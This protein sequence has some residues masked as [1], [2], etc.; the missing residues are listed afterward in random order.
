MPQ[1]LAGIPI[2]N[3]LFNRAICKSLPPYYTSK[4]SLMSGRG[5]TKGISATLVRS[6]KRAVW[7][8]LEEASKS[9]FQLK[10]DRV[11]TISLPD[12]LFVAGQV[13]DRNGSL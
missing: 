7:W 1:Q 8:A 4:K 12:D 3:I 13:R 5:A 11:P 6:L 9:V 10:G 2:R